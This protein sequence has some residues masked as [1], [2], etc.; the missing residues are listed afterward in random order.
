MIKL[1]S[2]HKRLDTGGRRIEMDDWMVYATLVMAT[3]SIIMGIITA[4]M[5]R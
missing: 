1:Q 4:F 5:N 3:L 2:K